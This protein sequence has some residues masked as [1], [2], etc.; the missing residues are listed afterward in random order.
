ME[1]FESNAGDKFAEITAT[2]ESAAGVLREK[3]RA[4]ADEWCEG[5]GLHLENITATHESAAAYE[6]LKEKTTKKAQDVRCRRLPQRHI[7]WYRPVKLSKDRV[8]IFLSTSMAM[9][10]R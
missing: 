3:V 7:A 1:V 5:F 10:W 8:P 6:R 4:A 9:D 2:E